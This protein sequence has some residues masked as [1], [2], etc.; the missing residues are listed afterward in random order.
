M[1][2]NKVLSNVPIKVCVMLSKRIFC[3]EC[4]YVGTCDAAIAINIT[5]KGKSSNCY[6]QA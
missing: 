5:L 1:W 6:K 3:I 4:C 2:F